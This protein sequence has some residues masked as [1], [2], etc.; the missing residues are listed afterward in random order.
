MY[1]NTY[2]DHKQDRD[3]KRCFGRKEKLIDCDYDFLS[4]LRTLKEPHEP[5]PRLADLLEY[6]AQPGLEEI[7][8]LLDIK[9]C[10]P[11]LVIRYHM[12]TIT[13]ARQQ[14]RRCYASDRRDH[15]Q[16]SALAI[17]PMARSHRARVLGSEISAIM[18]AVLARLS[19]IAYRLLDACRI[20]LLHSA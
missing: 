10:A 15:P 11:H 16:C 17:T 9:V 13:T 3:L 14:R 12:L 2:T 19:S 18:L 8:V 5:M 1:L 20:L 6:L 7:W 4:K